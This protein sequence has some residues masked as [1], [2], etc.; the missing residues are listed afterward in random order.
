MLALTTVIS[1]SS[2]STRAGAVIFSMRSC[3]ALD[4]G[5][6]VLDLL[7]HGFKALVDGIEFLIDGFKAFVD[8]IEFLIDRFKLFIV[9]GSE[10][11]DLSVHHGFHAGFGLLEHL[12]H[13]GFHFVF[14]TGFRLAEHLFQDLDVF[15]FQRIHLLSLSSLGILHHN[16]QGR[17]C[18]GRDGQKNA[19]K[20]GP[21]AGEHRGRAWSFL[22][23]FGEKLSRAWA[24]RR[25][26]WPGPRRWGCSR[27][28]CRR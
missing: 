14:H 24:G 18:Q 11:V 21:P 19:E 10:C 2:L 20:P 7:V 9:F 6:G 3:V 17:G 16:R 22:L 13:T 27:A 1:S 25:S 15:F 8:G 5:G 28:W 4:L 23:V 12:D 26:P